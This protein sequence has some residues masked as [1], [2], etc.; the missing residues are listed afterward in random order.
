MPFTT[1]SRGHTMQLPMSHA[2]RRAA[3]VLLVAAATGCTTGGGIPATKAPAG[4]M[5]PVSG[6]AS[7]ATNAID[8]VALAA[9]LATLGYRTNSPLALATA[10]QLL[11]DNPAQAL[12]VTPEIETV[13]ATMQDATKSG[14]EVSLDVTRLL[15]AAQNAAR[16]NSNIAGLVSQLRQRN[17][18]GAK[19][20]TYG[21]RSAF[22][23]LPANST[24]AFRITFDGGR[25][26]SIRVRG[27]G[28]TD[29]DCWVIDSSGRT[30][31]QDTDYTDYCI[32]DWY[33]EVTNQHRLVI[34]NWSSSIYNRYHLTTN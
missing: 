15:D 12:D 2:T 32:L 24:H 29:L 33:P 9:D 27:D 19:G 16:D 30:V 20:A 13:G 5:Q 25:R 14:R 7:P 11:L 28:D 6:G 8:A 23:R 17:A 18:S 10:A 3:A 31:A 21:A 1:R 22:Y 4:G 34:K 26:A